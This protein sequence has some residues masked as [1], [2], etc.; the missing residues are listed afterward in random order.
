MKP[1]TRWI[2]NAEDDLRKM[3]IKLRRLRTADR[4]EGEEYGR[5]SVFCNN[6]SATE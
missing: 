2:D 3:G 4:R 6:S 1:R 5:R